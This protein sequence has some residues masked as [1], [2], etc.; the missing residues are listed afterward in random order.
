MVTDVGS[1]EEETQ[2]KS[3][4]PAEG[5]HYKIGTYHLGRVSTAAPPLPPPTPRRASFLSRL[6]IS[7]EGEAEGHTTAQTEQIVIGAASV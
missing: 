7:H 5:V 4:F 1:R 2:R 3:L 6:L